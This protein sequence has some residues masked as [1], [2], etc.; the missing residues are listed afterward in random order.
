ME[1]FASYEGIDSKWAPIVLTIGNFDAVHRGHCALLGQ[2]QKIAEKLNGHLF[3]LTFANHPAELLKE[4][5]CV[6]KL[7]TQVQKLKLLSDQSVDGV[8]LLEFTRQFSAQTAVQFIG[9]L[10]SHLAFK[11]LVLGHDARIGNDRQGDSPLMRQL[12]DELDFMLQYI[13]PYKIEGS[14]VSSSLIR[15]AINNGDLIAAEK[16]LGRK[17]S[18]YLPVPNAVAAAG[19]LIDQLSGLCLPPPGTYKVTVQSLNA[20]YTGH[21]IIEHAS[22]QPVLELK[23]AHKFKLAEGPLE[24]IFEGKFN[25]TCQTSVCCMSGTPG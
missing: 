21:A 1:M 5:T 10:H 11:A 22:G 20:K 17:Y 2:A 7:C 25:G 16:M 19:V 3:V 9:S 23:F 13:P 8:I 18:I 6:P 14:I 24:I 4:G 12:A 15:Q